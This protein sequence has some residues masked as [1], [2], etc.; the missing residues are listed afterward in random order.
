MPAPRIETER[1]ILRAI[2]PERD[3]D[4]WATAMADEETVR[5]IGGNVM[6]RA[7]AWRSMATVIGHWQ[8]RGYGFFSVE[9]KTTGQWVGRGGPWFP[10]G[11]PEPEIGWTIMREHWGRG[12]A[13]EAGA[14]C[15]DYVRDTLGWKQVIHAIL[16]GNLGSAA[17]AEKLGSQRLREQQGLGGVTD[18]TVWIYGQTF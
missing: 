18:D 4:A 13:T 11:W 16:E 12:L 6:D 14:A 9:E 1:L 8:I 7:T 17:V 15:I 10:E 3:F 5:Y 2:D